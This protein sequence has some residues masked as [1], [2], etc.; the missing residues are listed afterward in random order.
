ME[1]Y[2][3]KDVVLLDVF[4]DMLICFKAEPGFFQVKKWTAIGEFDG[5]WHG[6]WHGHVVP[7]WPQGGFNQE[8]L[9]L[10]TPNLGSLS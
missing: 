9:G 8:H 2:G 3:D 5:I 4:V 1:K 10:L 7:H 6:I